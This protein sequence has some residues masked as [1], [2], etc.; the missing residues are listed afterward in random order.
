MLRRL[1]AKRCKLAIRVDKLLALTFKHR[2][3]DLFG[4]ERVCVQPCPH[5]GGGKVGGAVT[6]SG[7]TPALERLSYA[8]GKPKHITYMARLDRFDDLP[9]TL[10]NTDLV[11]GSAPVR[12]P[13]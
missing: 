9:I 13:R 2:S 8:I 6:A 12:V 5:R 1:H 3:R 7:P 11:S 4:D 10:H